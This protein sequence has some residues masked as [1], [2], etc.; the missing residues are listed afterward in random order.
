MQA[1][2]TAWTDPFPEEAG[3]LWYIEAGCLRQSALRSGLIHGF[4]QKPSG[5]AR[6]FAAALYLDDGE[7]S[8]VEM[9]NLRRTADVRSVAT[10]APF[11]G[12]VYATRWLPALRLPV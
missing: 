7:R 11:A 4:P 10:S 6:I 1:N 2:G 12:L 5:T 9:S 3:S 8:Q